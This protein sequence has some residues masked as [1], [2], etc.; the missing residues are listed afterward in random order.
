MSESSLPA[1][2][3]PRAAAARQFVSTTAVEAFF[4]AYRRATGFDPTDE[5]RLSAVGAASV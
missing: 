3:F 4:D 1:P 5:T 2:E